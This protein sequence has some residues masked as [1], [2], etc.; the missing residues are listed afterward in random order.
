MRI[1]KRVK[2][3]GVL[4]SKKR[5]IFP[6]EKWTLKESFQEDLSRS[7]TLKFWQTEEKILM[8]M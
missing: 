1:K 3:K 4:D 7:L 8:T 5:T 6:K 2:T